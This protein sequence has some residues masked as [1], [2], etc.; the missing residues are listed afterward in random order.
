MGVVKGQGHPVIQIDNISALVHFTQDSHTYRLD[1]ATHKL[2]S[3]FKPFD[4]M[5]SEK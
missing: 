4:I 2:F 5:V 3:Q 1:Q